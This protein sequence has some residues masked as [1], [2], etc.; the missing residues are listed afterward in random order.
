M[1][2]FIYKDCDLGQHTMSRFGPPFVERKVQ[3]GLLRQY[4]TAKEGAQTCAGAKRT[5]IFASEEYIVLARIGK[6]YELYVTYK[7]LTSKPQISMW[8][9]SLKKWVRAQGECLF[10]PPR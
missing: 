2:H 10:A 6:S 3:K 7:P 5:V 4:L 9:T 1:L 8:A